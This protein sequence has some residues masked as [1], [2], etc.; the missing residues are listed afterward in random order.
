[1]SLA[2]HE[3]ELRRSLRTLQL[4]LCNLAR[5]DSAMSGCAGSRPC[6]Q[7]L[8]D[9]FFDHIYDWILI[10]FFYQYYIYFSIVFMTEFCTNLICVII[11]YDRIYD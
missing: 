7:P 3:L 10:L 11:I 5:L 2:T 9:I 1:M 4:Y 6:Q 8:I